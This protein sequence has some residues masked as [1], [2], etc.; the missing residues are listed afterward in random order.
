[1]PEGANH[2]AY[3]CRRST[4]LKN[5]KNF[6]D[7]AEKMQHRYLSRQ[8]VRQRHGTTTT[9]GSLCGLNHHFCSQVSGCTQTGRE[10]TLLKLE[11]ESQWFPCLAQKL[12]IGDAELEGEQWVKLMK[13]PCFY[14]PSGECSDWNTHAQEPPIMVTCGS[15][16]CTSATDQ[17]EMHYTPQVAKLVEEW[18]KDDFEVLN[19]PKWDGEG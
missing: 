8:R 19:Y 9:T 3:L 14:T 1:M 6:T 18:Y 11:L 16:H 13:K 4:W 15:V 2:R 5:V 10:T 12:H 17:L 7:F